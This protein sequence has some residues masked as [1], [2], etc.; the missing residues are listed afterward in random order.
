MFRFH[1]VPEKAQD[2]GLISKIA[3]VPLMGLMY[4]FVFRRAKKYHIFGEKD[5]QPKILW[6][7]V[8]LTCVLHLLGLVGKVLHI[9]H[10]YFIKQF[11][12]H[13]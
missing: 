13:H 6:Q 5:I 2:S 11:A 4:E 10:G 9:T 12:I 7:H 1:N 8:A 3:L